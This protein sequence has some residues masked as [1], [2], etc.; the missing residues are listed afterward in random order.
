MK[1]KAVFCLT[2]AVLLLSLVLSACGGSSAPTKFSILEWS[3][4]E[5]EPFWEPYAQQYPDDPPSWSFFAD[6][7]E[8]L[9]KAQTGFEF[10]LV[11]PCSSWWGLYVDQGLVQPIDTSKLDHF[12]ELYPWLAEQGQFNGEQ[13]FIP[14]DWGYESILVRTDLVDEVPSSWADLWD[15][16]YAG[17]V[18]IF[19]SSETVF[20]TT[21]VALGIDPY[22]TSTEQ[23]EMI[24]Q[25]LIELKPNLLNFWSDFTEIN[26]LVAQGDVWVAGN[27]WNDAY[28]SLSDEGYAVD[29]IVPK[30]GR[31]G[32]MCGYGISTDADN[33]DQAYAFLNALTDPH[34]MAN[35]GNEFY[36]GVASQ[37]AKELLD[38]YIV[39]LMELDNPTI[40][41]STQFY[42]T[43]T[44]EQRQIRENIFLEVKAAN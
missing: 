37:T 1:R 28:A 30:E 14:Y 17:H 13:Y 19:D 32:W 9:A 41:E 42:Q 7:A 22:N 27:T 34:S 31:L 24:K 18:S 38:P 10:D 6:D 4:Y 16:Q 36:Y 11:H 35:M 20:L 39:E 26:Q 2:I 3:G 23:D 5:L 21:A 44:E 33:L 15:P 8:A 25:K 29:Y 12:D 43:L 40:L